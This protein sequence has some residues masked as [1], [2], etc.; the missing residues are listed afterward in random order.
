MTN[1]VNRGFWQVA[2]DHRRA[3]ARNQHDDRFNRLMDAAY[4][5]R[6]TA[7]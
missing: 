7:A 1:D 3:T 5:R 2:G 4:H 6:P